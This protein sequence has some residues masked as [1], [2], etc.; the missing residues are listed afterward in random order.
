[1]KTQRMKFLTSGQRQILT[2]CWRR[3]SSP[4]ARCWTSFLAS[5]SFHHD[6]E[7]YYQ[8]GDI[9]RI[10]EEPWIDSED[11]EVIRVEWVRTGR[12]SVQPVESLA[13]YFKFYV[14]EKCQDRC[15]TEMPRPEATADGKLEKQKL[16][17]GTLLDVLPGQSFHHDG[18][19]YYR[20]GDI[21]RITKEIW[22]DSD[23]DEVIRINWNRGVTTTQPV[24]T[25]AEHFK[26]FTG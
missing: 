4:W 1:M 18:E 16:T 2:R 19:E 26:F 25:L 20:E 9:G 5:P 14:P 23:D 22:I 13:E 7:E 10:T 17:V 8:E 3:K 24:A 12:R 15:Q 6:G 21:G 11:D